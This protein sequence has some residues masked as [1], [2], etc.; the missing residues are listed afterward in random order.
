MRLADSRVEIRAGRESVVHAFELDSG[1]LLVAAWLRSS[2]QSGNPG[3]RAPDERQDTVSV[4]LPI[5]G[6]AELTA[7]DVGTGQP[8]RTSATLDGPLLSNVK[9]RGGGIFVA[10][11]VPATRR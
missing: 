1:E 5:S 9:L 4:R 11:I 6:R 8:T 7:F 2:P 3:G 10:R